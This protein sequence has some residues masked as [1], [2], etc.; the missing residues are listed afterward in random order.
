MQ[1]ST[2]PTATDAPAIRCLNCTHEYVGAFCP[3]CGQPA[4]ERRVTL[5][6][7]IRDFAQRFLSLEQGLIRSVYEMSID[8]G[9]VIR[10]YSEGQRRQYVGPLNYLVIGT[11]LMLLAHTLIDSHVTAW[12]QA[13][14]VDSFAEIKEGMS[15]GS[16]GTMGGLTPAQEQ[17]FIETMLWLS[18]KVML[19]S[20]A[21]GLPFAVMLRLLFRKT[22]V[23]LAET[24]VFTLYCFGHIMLVYALLV[25]PLVWLGLDF[26]LVAQ[27][28]LVLYWIV[29]CFAA[30]GFFGRRI[31]PVLKTAVAMGVAYAVFGVL[32][33]AGVA[34]YAITTA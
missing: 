29:P 4:E 23:N 6:R 16:G 19:T 13:T 15:L 12:M 25:A 28:S 9:G 18:K 21:M 32:L 31:G 14:L 1:Q 17:R 26:G 30:A 10:R 8:P 3:A 33:W 5:G 11:A 24:G 34:F 27:A 20:L 2:A 22:G 7:L